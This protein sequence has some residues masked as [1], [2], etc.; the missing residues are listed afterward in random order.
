MTRTWRALN[1]LDALL[2][3]REELEGEQT[4]GVGSGR[5]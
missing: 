3:E 4:A 1:V 2:A 5:F